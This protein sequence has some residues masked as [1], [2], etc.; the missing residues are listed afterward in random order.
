MNRVIEQIGTFWGMCRVTSIVALVG[1]GV[2]CLQ[3]GDCIHAGFSFVLAI[4]SAVYLI[5]DVKYYIG[6]EEAEKEDDT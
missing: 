3:E 5:I 4:I 1:T 6:D 2:K